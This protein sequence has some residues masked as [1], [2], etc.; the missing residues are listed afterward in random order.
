[1]KRM[2]E[3]EREAYNENKR[4]EIEAFTERLAE[5]VANIRT[6]EGYR[7][8][9]AFG[10]N[11][12]DY[13]VNNL[14]MIGMQKP[15]ATMVASYTNWKKVGR[16]VKKGEKGI[17]IFAPI[18][19]AMKP[20]PE[21]DP[22]DEQNAPKRRVCGYKLVSVFDVSQTDGEPI[23]EADFMVD[24]LD[25]DVDG[26]E[27]IMNAVLS[28]TDF[29]FRYENL[30]GECQGVCRPAA[31]TIAVQEGLSQMQTLK[32]TIHETAHSLLHEAGCPKSR[33]EKEIEAESVA[34]M[35]CAH[36]GLDVSDYSFGYVASW[37]QNLSDKDYIAVI[38]K[39]KGVAASMIKAVDAAMD[40]D[41]A[42]IA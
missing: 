9:L 11:F 24:S 20:D 31:K 5:G 36:L 7:K 22:D 26:F 28:T 41:A 17:R 15:D 40:D 39:I 2:S 35:V 3:K 19:V 16:F 12:Y 30:Q 8:L 34:Y 23:P 21:A 1:M 10:S 14:L 6:S 29:R 32:T 37:A 4:Q 25:G 13:S 42:E 38:N 33:E 18:T 27:D